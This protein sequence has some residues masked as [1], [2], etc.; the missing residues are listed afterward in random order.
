MLSY[1]LSIGRTK[2]ANYLFLAMPLPDKH[3]FQSSSQLS[4]GR[5]ERI[6]QRPLGFS[7]L[8]LRIYLSILFS[9]AM[10]SDESNRPSILP[11]PCISRGRDQESFLPEHCFAK[12]RHAQSVLRFPPL[13]AGTGALKHGRLLAVYV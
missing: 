2:L 8:I 3:S 7:H 13:S 6:Y 11:V 9:L 5:T 4:F 1:V 12:Q 10:I